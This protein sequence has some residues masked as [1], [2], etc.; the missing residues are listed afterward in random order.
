[1]RLSRLD[2]DGHLPSARARLRA[3]NPFRLKAHS[4][5]SAVSF[6]HHL[7]ISFPLARRNDAVLHSGNPSTHCQFHH[8]RNSVSAT[9]EQ[10]FNC[11]GGLAGTVS[12]RVR[13]DRGH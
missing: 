10:S 4:K 12:S 7:S 8:S 3:Q 5:P 9:A 6:Q 11:K 1:M 13:T 2:S